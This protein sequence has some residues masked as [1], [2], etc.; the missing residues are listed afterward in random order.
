MQ[1]LTTR[2]TLSGKV[3]SVRGDKTIFVE[4][5]SY[6]SHN[7]YSKRYRVVKRFAVHDEKLLASVGDIVTIMETRPLSKTK[8]FRL[9]EIK[10]KA[11]RGEE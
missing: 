8:H 5:E 9:V 2:K 1:R 4:V 6:R 10:H 7:L 3:T 11:Q